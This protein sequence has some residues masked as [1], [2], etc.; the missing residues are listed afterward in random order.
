MSNLIVYPSTEPQ[1][2]SERCRGFVSTFI[3]LGLAVC[4]VTHVP[5]CFKL[6]RLSDGLRASS[7]H[8][9]LLQNSFHWTLAVAT[10]LACIAPPQIYLIERWAGFSIEF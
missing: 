7:T 5:A 8:S 3:R 1:N 6:Q 2:F 9:C 4:P 10:T